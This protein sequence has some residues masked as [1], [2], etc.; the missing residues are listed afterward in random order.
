M[1][2]LTI[3]MFLVSVLYGQVKF[4]KI[5]EISL[6][7][8]PEKP[9]I[10]NS[11][12]YGISDFFVNNKSIYLRNYDS[13]NVYKFE[14][15]T[16]SKVLFSDGVIYEHDKQLKNTNS[17]DIF[18]KVANNDIYFGNDGAYSDAS[19]NKINVI[20]D[21][22]NLIIE[23]SKNFSTVQLFNHN[24][25]FADLIGID[26]DDN[27]YLITETILQQIPLI[28][29]RNIFVLNKLS[30]IL[31][32]ISV[33]TNKYLTISNEFS[34]DTEGNIYHFLSDS[35]KITI[36][37]ISGLSLKSKDTIA[38]P[39]EYN[40]YVHY[41]QFT[42]REEIITDLSLINEP[43]LA[44]SRNNA[45][46]IA[47]SYIS[48]KYV[49]K[50]QNLAP[51]GITAP[52]GDVVKTPGYLIKGWNAKIPY[53]WGGF[54]TLAD[55]YSGITYS[56]FYAGDIHTSGVTS[57]AVGVDC[58]GYVSRCWQLSYHASTAYMPNITTQLSDWTKIKPGDA[59]LKSG[60]VR[61]YVNRAQN[62]ALRIAESSGRDWA[63]SYWSYSLSDLSSYTPNRYNSMEPDFNETVINLYSSLKI[64]NKVKLV[65]KADTT[66]LKGYRLYRSVNGKNWYTLLDENSLTG[67]SVLIDMPTEPTFYRI[68]I[69]KN[70]SSEL[71]ESNWSNPVGVSP[72]QTTKNY[73]IIDGF[74]RNI[75]SASFQGPNNPYA[76]SYALGLKSAGASFE[77]IKNTALKLDSINLNNYYGIFWY[78]GDESSGDESIDDFEQDLLKNYLEN[79][80]N[81]FLCGSEIGYDLYEKGA[82]SDKNF[83]ANYL[84]AK[85]ISDNASSTIVKTTAFASFDILQ[86]NIGQT[87]AE[88]YPDVIDPLNGSIS[89]FNYANNKGAGIIYEGTF[90]SSLQKGKLVYLA[91]PLETTADDTSFNKVIRN[92]KSFF[93]NPLTEIKEDLKGEMDF[94]IENAYPNPFN[95][96]TNL[97]F[98]LNNTADVKIT[99]F[100]ILGQEICV[101]QNGMLNSGKYN[102]KF[103]NNQ[104]S[105]GIYI[106]NFKINS[107]IYNLKLS[108]IK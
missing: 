96:S 65:W 15:K 69:V 95:A 92:V 76:I 49:C 101:L 94:K 83:F 91:F 10:E 44:I 81:L 35:E 40:K 54:S 58:S 46:K 20:V 18:A 41:D 11:G 59:V 88:D 30:E 38:Y 2:Y 106:A 90:G 8:L 17:N 87:Y 36:L 7:D 50:T 85:Y 93:E 56:N 61:L 43:R 64:Q 97:S 68:S 32:K 84:K 105:T 5:L 29:E 24:I 21:N 14:N 72:T 3:C 70:G 1:R 27:Y 42:T 53:M 16:L 74:N 28:V 80:G 12:I 9:R 108:L 6:N 102:I 63:V 34:L 77:I 104:I 4:E 100:N 86:F 78:V 47:D 75:G 48:F 55:F 23:D 60:H 52:D 31:N 25:A 13:K 73:L 62:G 33:P 66:N 89:S 103:E 98:S 107:K 22:S 26:N 99:I 19:G 51:N 45:L 79:G 67:S 37:K 57:Y 82:E 39:E 71:L